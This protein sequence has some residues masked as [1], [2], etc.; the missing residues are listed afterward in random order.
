MN[1][2]EALS[3][4]FFGGAALAMGRPDVAV[5][6]ESPKPKEER[7]RTL[8]FAHLTDV[9]VDSKRDAASGLAAAIRHVHELPDPPA[10]L[11]NGGDA[12]YDA[13]EVSREAVEQQWSLWDAAWK[14]FGKLPVKHCLGNHDIWGWNRKKSRTTG[15]EPGWGKAYALERLGLERSYGSFDAGG[16]RFFVLDSMM[17][18]EETA[19]RAQLDPEQME[20]LTNGLRT[21]P[22]KT[23][24]VI[25]SHIP[26]L[27]VGGVGFTPE[28]RKF[29]QASRILTHND[30]FEL[31]NL[32]QKHSNVKLC[33][34]GHS[35]LTETI[36]FGPLAFVN[37]GA[38]SGLWWKGHFRHTAEGYNVVDLFDDG[39]FATSYRTYGWQAQPTRS[40]KTSPAAG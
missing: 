2:R 16:W 3:T 6:A 10:F 26:I 37:S 30:A 40:K 21:T 5:A 7:K 18:D 38:V 32:F 8:R 27:S 17:F 22:A 11:L 25:V 15:Q 28:V 33:L 1:R 39:T 29:P 14:E 24:I 9:H 19:Y 31:L 4:V 13:L 35:H 23:P 20:W 12:I 34:S 36:S